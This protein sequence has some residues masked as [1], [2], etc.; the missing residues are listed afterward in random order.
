MR[1]CPPAQT[2]REALAVMSRWGITRVTDIT[3]LDR[4]G[5]PVFTS[6]R[7]RGRVLR[8]HAGK[9]LQAVDARV[10][11]VMEALEHAVAEPDARALASARQRPCG[12][13]QDD[14][15]GAWR[16]VDLAPAFGRALAADDPLDTVRCEWWHAGVRAGDAWL[17]A[18]L[19]HMPWACARP[20]FGVTSNGLASGNTL[21][22]ATLHGAL[23]V[24]ERDALS[25]A[26]AAT[27]LPCLR[28]DTLPAPFAAMAQAWQACGVTLH[29]RALPSAA[30]LPCFQAVLHE[31]DGDIPLAEGSGL[32]PDAAIALSRAVC[33]AAQARAV[34]LQGSR[35]DLVVS[36]DAREDVSRAERPALE[37]RLLSRFRG[38]VDT[39]AWSPAPPLLDLSRSLDQ[40]LHDL[41]GLLA[42]HGFAHVLRHAFPTD[43]LGGLCVVRV[44]I[45]RCESMD[46]PRPMRLGP[47]LL[48]RV[49]AEA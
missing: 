5:M 12:Q 22:E 7:P 28:V 26:H 45:P 30:G 35:D 3:R 18:E 43:H 14:W 19:V 40:V 1:T 21:A 16:L 33:E 11:A 20:L 6:V 37:H 15:Q 8:V 27:A 10:G 25:M 29:V 39:V 13:L 24:L 36:F 34:S 32:H 41:L 23:E 46:G 49:L 31:P 47:R 4:L 38:G 42:R 2:L 44:V 9:G 17:P 48:A